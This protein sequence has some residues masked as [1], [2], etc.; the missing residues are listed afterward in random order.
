MG[1]LCD[2]F[3]GS[4]IPALPTRV[5]ICLRFRMLDLSCTICALLYNVQA[6]KDTTLMHH[7]AEGD[8]GT[9][10]TAPTASRRRGA[11]DLQQ[12]RAKLGTRV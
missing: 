10:R 5:A 3:A 9:K 1:S 2:K 6:K 4:E 8:R 7:H 12:Q 11:S